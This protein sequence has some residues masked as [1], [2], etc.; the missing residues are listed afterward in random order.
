MNDTNKPTGNKERVFSQIGSSMP[1][2]VIPKRETTIVTF[3]KFFFAFVKSAITG[4]SVVSVL[5]LS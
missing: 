5:R 4:S 3:S 1:T 2:E